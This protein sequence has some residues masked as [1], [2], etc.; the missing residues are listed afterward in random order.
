[1]PNATFDRAR[2]HAGLDKIHAWVKVVPNDD[3]TDFGLWSGSAIADPS[4]YE[5]GYK[6]AR[7]L[8]IGDLTVALSS[9]LTGRM[10]ATSFSFEASDLPDQFNASLGAKI[11]GWLGQGRTLKN[12]EVTVKFITDRQRHLGYTPAVAFRGVVD[13]YNGAAKFRMRF[14]CTSWMDPR[15]DQPVVRRTIGESWANA[16]AEFAALPAPIALGRLRDDGSELGS[17]PT[18]AAEATSGATAAAGP[19]NLNATG[20]FASFANGVS[21]PTGGALVEELASGDFL[22][23]DSDLY[24]QYW[25]EDAGVAGDPD[26]ASFAFAALGVN[27]SVTTNGSGLRAT[28]DDDSD[29]ATYC[30]AIGKLY[31]G[32]PKYAQILKTTTPAVG[33]LFTRTPGA[34]GIPI[35]QDTDITPGAILAFSAIKDYTITAMMTDG[36]TSVSNQWRF[37]NGPYER[38]AR[39]VADPTPSAISYT[40]YRAD[41]AQ[42][43]DR[44][45]VFDTSQV[46]GAGDIYFEDDFLTP[47]AWQI[48]AAPLERGRIPLIPVGPIVDITNTTW[49]LA[50]I[51]AAHACDI[52]RPPKIYKYQVT[53]RAESVSGQLAEVDEPTVE[54]VGTPGTSNYHYR[55]VAKDATGGHASASPVGSTSIGNATL[56]GTDYNTIAWSAVSG[57]AEYDVYRTGGPGTHGLIATTAST[58][59]DDTGLTGDGSSAPTTNTTGIVRP[60]VAA[61]TVTPIDP[62]MYGVDVAA[63]GQTGYATYFGASPYWTTSDGKRWMIVAYRSSDYQDFLDGSQQLR[64]NV[65]GAEPVGD[66]SGDVITDGYDQ[67]ALLADNLDLLDETS[68]LGED[69]RTSPPTFS[70][71][72]EKRDTASWTL[73]KANASAVL[74]QGADCARYLTEST[75]WSDLLAEGFRSLRIL[76]GTATSGKFQIVVPNPNQTPA[77]NVDHVLDILDD[78][79]PGFQD[80]DQLW[81][82]ARAYAFNPAYDAVGSAPTLEESKPLEDPY[83]Q[84]R[85]RQRKL[86]DVLAL[87]WRQTEY[88]AAA[89]AAL[90]LADTTDLPRTV[91]MSS[92]IHW[93]QYQLGDILLTTHPEGPKALG[94]VDDPL[95][96]L[97]LRLGLGSLVVEATCID[98]HVTPESDMAVGDLKYLGGDESERVLLTAYPSGA[99]GDKLHHGSNIANFDSATLTGTF[100]FEAMGNVLAGGQTLTVGLFNLSDGAPDTPIA[101]VTFTSTTPSRQRSASAIAFGAAGSAKSYG[102]KAKVSAAGEGFAWGATILRTA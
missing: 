45:Q 23:G 22:A 100:H 9:A 46:N 15:L 59:L 35:D 14:D 98:R 64:A 37:I 47:A 90:A 72:T 21:V 97:G 44:K 42:A 81:A 43:Y 82:N 10:Q 91:P 39:I 50:F 66:A 25:K 60:A 32:R 3:P 53:D 29:G 68:V 57:A 73:A 88:H 38:P 86:G 94:Y 96:I 58:T 17:S 95:Q 52:A 77:G 54:P 80:D 67:L 83:S 69:W 78:G 7:L 84:T 48:A 26:A 65:L 102:V 89:V 20:G 101:T 99:G 74:P 93:A 4:T 70:D 12:A 49:S 71:A 41:V 63:P 55:I 18:P 79:F 8:L 34:A 61:G 19:G 87:P 13:R 56:S 36:E 27:A 16:P 28:C 31:A 51:W 11:R 5:D 6:E 62:G 2:L 85:H 33:V 92:A 24:L 1:M 30:F 76:G 40:A 75:T